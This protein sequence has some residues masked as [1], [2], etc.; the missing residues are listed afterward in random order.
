MLIEF[1]KANLGVEDVKRIEKMIDPP[2]KQARSE[3]INN[4][5]DKRLFLYEVPIS[6]WFIIIILELWQ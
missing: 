6:V 5:L 4:T 1:I 3:N 2:M